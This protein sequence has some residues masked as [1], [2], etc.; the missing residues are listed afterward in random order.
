[1]SW[2]RAHPQGFLDGGFY[3]WIDGRFVAD[4]RPHQVTPITQ[5][6]DSS[7]HVRDSIEPG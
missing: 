3:T 2:L 7:V 6:P 1:M 5:T 4:E